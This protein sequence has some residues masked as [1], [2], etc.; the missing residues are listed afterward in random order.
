MSI[1]IDAGKAG[2]FVS[3]GSTLIGS[4]PPEKDLSPVY[5]FLTVTGG[6]LAYTHAL[7]REE[8]GDA[9]TLSEVSAA[10]VW[11]YGSGVAS[12]RLPDSPVRVFSGDR[13]KCGTVWFTVVIIPTTTKWSMEQ[14]DD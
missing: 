5:R 4:R 14:I 2:T 1:L 7:L 12:R 13:F 6:G 10:G 8:K 3:D 11:L 9:W